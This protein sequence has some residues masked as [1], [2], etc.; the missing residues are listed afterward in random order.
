MLHVFYVRLLGLVRLTSSPKRPRQGSLASYVSI[1]IIRAR[2]DARSG[3]LQEISGSCAGGQ[4][5][6]S[7]ENHGLVLGCP[8]HSAA[9]CWDC[10]I[11]TTQAKEGRL[12]REFVVV[13]LCFVSKLYAHMWRLD[14]AR[15]F[16]F[17]L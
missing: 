3:R 8:L 11:L 7:F 1:R 12:R 5:W 17:L 14:M 4:V 16:S 15:N 6:A 9:L 13:K 2:R 10:T